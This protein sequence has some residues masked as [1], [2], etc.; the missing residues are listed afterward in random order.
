VPGLPPAMALLLRRERGQLALYAAHVTSEGYAVACYRPGVDG[1]SGVLFETSGPV[2]CLVDEGDGAIL[3]A[4]ED[5][6]Y[7][8]SVGGAR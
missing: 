4:A 1:G 8:L 6:L 7:R 2:H 5:G 3:V